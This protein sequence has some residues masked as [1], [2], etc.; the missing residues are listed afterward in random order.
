MDYDILSGVWRPGGLAPDNSVDLH[1]DFN[2]DNDDNLLSG[3]QF[4]S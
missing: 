2:D 3:L 1:I 4:Y